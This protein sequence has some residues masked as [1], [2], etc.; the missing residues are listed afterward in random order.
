MDQN[1]TGLSMSNFGLLTE[2]VLS[3]ISIFFADLVHVNAEAAR[4]LCACYWSAWLLPAPG[5]G[6]INGAKS[7]QFDFWNF[8]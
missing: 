7:F 5:D 1:I 8:W 2:T 3:L 6:N 4:L